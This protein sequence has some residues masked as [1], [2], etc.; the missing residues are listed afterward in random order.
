M[1]LLV[2]EGSE[3]EPRVWATLQ[4]LY[5]SGTSSQIKCSL[6][7]DTRTLW[8]EM[9]SHIANGYEAEVFTVVKNHLK[10]KGDNSLDSVSSYQIEAV[11][12][13]FDYDPQNR[14]VSLS[15]LNR[16]MTNMLSLFDD[17][18][19]NGKLFINY[20]MLE[21]MYCLNGIPDA[22]YLSAKVSV[23]DCHGFKAWCRSFSV[24]C[25]TNQLLFRINRS[26]QVQ[27][28]SSS[29][30]ILLRR[31]WDQIVIMNAKKANLI[32]NGDVELPKSEEDIDQSL[33]WQHELADFVLVSS[34]VSLLGAFPLFLFE[35]FH[36]NGDF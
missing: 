8:R 7:A 13:F 5:F 6:G 1:I 24:A 31:A 33:I 22:G 29:A 35:Y 2:F 23:S 10:A 9:Q 21:S 15:D 25:R 26:G 18:M 19:G 12:L 32:C 4:N 3:H 30:M 27:L 11:Y 20:P 17:A 14:T 36:G 34:E 28:P 16:T